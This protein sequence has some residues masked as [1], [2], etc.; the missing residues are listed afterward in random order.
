MRRL[1]WIGAAIAAFTMSVSAAFADEPLDFKVSLG[2]SAI[3]PTGDLSLGA[4][5]ECW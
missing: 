4:F 3:F 5:S 2:A 1:K